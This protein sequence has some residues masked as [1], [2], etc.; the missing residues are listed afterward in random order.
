[1]DLAKALIA[2]GAQVNDRLDFQNPNFT[3]Q[4]MALSMFPG[5]SYS[6]ATP[7]FIASKNCDVEFMK[8]LLANGADPMI[9][10]HENVTPLHAA[11]GIG[12]AT[13]ESPGTPEEALEAVKL[14]QSVGNDVKAVVDFG[15][16]APRSMRASWDGSTALHGAVIREAKGLVEYLIAQGVPLDHRNKSKE[17]ALDVANGSSL[18]ITFHVYPELADI[19]RKAMI[20]QGLPITP[21]RGDTQPER[22]R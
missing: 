15:G 10:T 11:A 18:G 5:T 4:H 22:G 17:T 9:G 14:L 19:I 1:M 13:G 7:L 2:R 12:Y 6:G 20:A 16:S 8:F 21:A 3:P